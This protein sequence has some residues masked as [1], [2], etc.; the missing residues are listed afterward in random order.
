MKLDVYL[1]YCLFA[2]NDREAAACLYGVK[3]KMYELKVREYVVVKK[4]FLDVRAS[5]IDIS[6]NG[7]QIQHLKTLHANVFLL[8]GVLPF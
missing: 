4:L 7:I 3:N 1:F 6:A 8:V 5:C 2:F